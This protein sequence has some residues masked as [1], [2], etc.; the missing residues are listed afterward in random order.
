MRTMTAA[1]QIVEFASQ[2]AADFKRLNLEWLEKYFYVEAI[3]EIVLGNPQAEIIDGGGQILFALSDGEVCG[4]VALK[5]CGAGCYELT[6]MAVTA[7]RQG[8]GIGRALMLAAISKF[9]DLAGK[10]LYLE[11]HSSLTTAIALYESAGFI[12]V[13][14]PGASEYVRADTYM[15]FRS[16][17]NSLKNK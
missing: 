5:N 7:D 13:K 8:L 2:Y 4:T 11:T 12:H 9:R 14:P 17:S 6:K 10:K 16:N 3:D 15:V 1:L